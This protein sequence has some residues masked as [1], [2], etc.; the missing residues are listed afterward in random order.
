MAWVRS[1]ADNGPPVCHSYR[2]DTARAFKG[3]R[4]LPTCLYLDLGQLLAVP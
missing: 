2:R 1:V 3:V 4:R